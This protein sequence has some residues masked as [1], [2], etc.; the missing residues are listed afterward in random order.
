[1]AN[2]ELIRRLSLKTDSKIIFL[3]IDG[4]G[5]LPRE[6]EGGTEIEEA[7][8]P[9]LD[10][11]TRKGICGMIDPISPG[12][13][14][15]SGPAHL[16]LFGYD[17]V[18]YK[19]GRGVL[20]ALGIGFELKPSDVASRFNFATLDEKGR[21][22]D[23]RAGR[24][25]SEEGRKLCRL[26]DGIKLPGVKVF[27][28]PVK[29]YRGVLILRG[30]GLSGELSDSDPQAL[31]VL[32]KPVSSISPEGE[33]TANLVT[34]FVERAREVLKGHHPANFILLRGFD[35][36]HPFPTMS[37]IYKLTPASIANYPMYRGVTRLIGMEILETGDKITDEL[38]TLKENYQRF[39]FFYFHIKKPDSAGEDG[40]FDLRVK[41]FEEI[42]RFIPE[43]L[44]LDP[45]VLVITGD[46]STPAM[47]KAHSWHPV[48]I[49]LYSK[50]CRPD[51]VER[52]SEREFN[53]G[54]L[55]RFPATEL[56]LIAMANALK[57]SKYGA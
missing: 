40:D 27:V 36:Y 8:T 49:L 21:V 31:N 4:L 1:M 34:R 33:K 9:N 54:G 22:I 43:I 12:I 3:I 30:E 41:L 15:G 39:D 2:F 26:L 56:M 19:V 28:R 55:S 6:P 5:G 53:S 13:T 23:R 51:K 47:L 46:H 37:E 52:F 42:D 29:E 32:P 50:W 44:E 45:E 48:P 16:A 18:Q 17:P 57:L 25:P 24:V 14:P 38:T 11:L 10:E 35:K 7:R 20:A